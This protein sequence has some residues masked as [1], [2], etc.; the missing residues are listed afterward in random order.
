MRGVV[1][2]RHGAP[3]TQPLAALEGARNVRGERRHAM[4]CFVRGAAAP[5]FLRFL[6][7]LFFVG[8]GIVL[9]VGGLTFAVGF[10]TVGIF[11]PTKIVETVFFALS[12]VAFL[13]GVCV[14]FFA[15]FFVL[16]ALLEIGFAAF[17]CFIGPL[18]RPTSTAGMA[19]GLP[20]F[21]FPGLPNLFELIT[22]PPELIAKFGPEVVR[23]VECLRAS[24]CAKKCTGC[25]DGG[26]GGGGTPG[27][28]DAVDAGKAL[29]EQLREQLKNLTDRLAQAVATGN[30]LLANELRSQIESV[31]DRIRQLGG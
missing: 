15:T 8:L 7:G 3:F 17:N 22:M 2:R 13:A 14:T 12:V 6:P 19:V 30:L 27:V 18:L 9:A 24:F 31:N 25:G 1:G 28:G 21:S 10:A 23:L 29:L 11:E 16:M 5:F 4:G 26:G 20:G